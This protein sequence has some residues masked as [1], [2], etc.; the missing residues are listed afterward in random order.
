MIIITDKRKCSGCKA[1]LNICSSGAIIFQDDN[2]GVWYPTVNKNKCVQCGLCEKVCPFLSEQHG[3]PKVNTTYKAKYF[4]GQ[5]KEK[6]EL[7]NVSSGGAFQALALSILNKG[8]VIYG[9]TQENVDNVFH[10]RVTNF[11]DLKETRKSKYLQSDIG[12]CFVSAKKDLLDNKMV[13]FSGTGCQIAGLNCYLGRRYDNL[14]TCEV[15]CH[16]VPC[17]RV[18]MQY[19]KEKEKREGKRIVN[20]VFRDKSK[21]WSNNQYKIT[22]E[23][24]SKEYERSTV[25]LFHAG[26]LSGLFYRPSCGTCPF[27]SSPRVADITLADFWKYKGTLNKEDIGVSLIG[28]NNEHGLKLL[29]LSKPVLAIEN[30]TA[31]LAFNSCRHLNDHPVENKNR[32]K[33]LNKVYCDGYYPAAKVF[34]QSNDKHNFIRIL[35]RFKSIL[36]R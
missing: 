13:L 5:L 10:I 33:F 15:V 9:A 27:A 20:L 26:Y 19:R 24:G 1:C 36:W 35:T 16:G 8:G 25:Q 12:K 23:D 3:V 22:Y 21:G 4:A 14:Y 17:K 32:S 31:E 2:D 29:E 28:V 6:Q 18:W 11:D 30:T 34:I 7:P